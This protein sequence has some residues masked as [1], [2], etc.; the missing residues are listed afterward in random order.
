[1]K[2]NNTKTAKTNI[3]EHELQTFFLTLSSTAASGLPPEE[4]VD[5]ASAVVLWFWQEASGGSACL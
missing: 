2:Q 3:Q 5:L 4:M 1:M